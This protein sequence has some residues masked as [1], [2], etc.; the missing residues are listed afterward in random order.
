M[1]N[2]GV[3]GVNTPKLSVTEHKNVKQTV[4]KFTFRHRD[5]HGHFVVFENKN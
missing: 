2:N 4:R 5:K 1:W 3:Q